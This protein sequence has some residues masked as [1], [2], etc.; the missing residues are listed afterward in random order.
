MQAGDVKVTRADGSHQD[1][2]GGPIKTIPKWMPSAA[3]TRPEH[4]PGPWGT[5]R[6]G[7][8]SRTSSDAWLIVSRP[9]AIIARVERKGSVNREQGQPEVQGGR[10]ANIRQGQG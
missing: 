7:G 8:R 3:G 10:Q 4:P 2:T 1:R 9:G 5:G 6:A